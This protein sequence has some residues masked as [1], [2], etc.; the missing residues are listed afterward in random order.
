M[1]VQNWR[2]TG[3]YISTVGWRKKAPRKV[4]A[5]F[6]N[7]FVIPLRFYHMRVYRYLS[8]ETLN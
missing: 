3:E 8:R 7:P 4:S 6:P 2:F 1:C 5:R